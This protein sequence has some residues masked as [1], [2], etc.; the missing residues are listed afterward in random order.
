[1]DA[2]QVR[3]IVREEI[4]AA[5]DAVN[6][7]TFDLRDVYGFLEPRAQAEEAIRYIGEIYSPRSH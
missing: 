6:S 7:H 3:Q 1:M 2:E 4:T 5:L